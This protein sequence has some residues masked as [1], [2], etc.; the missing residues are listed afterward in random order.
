M[1]SFC[2]STNKHDDLESLSIL[3]EKTVFWVLR[4]IGCTVCRYDV[5]LIAERY[6]EFR[7]KNAQVYVLMQSDRTHVLN[8]LAKTD[9]HLPFEIITDPEMKIY[10]LLS[11]EPAESMEK[12]AEG[13]GEALREKA[14]LARKADFSHGDYEGNEQQLPALF[15]VNEDGSAAYAHYAKNIMDMPSLDEVLEML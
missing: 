12:L 9:T 8:D 2:F 5:K 6:Q 13:V 14:K 11:V 1:P 10:E 4:Y 15:I 7:D 3:K